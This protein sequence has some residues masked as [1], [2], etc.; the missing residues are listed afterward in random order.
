MSLCGQLTHEPFRAAQRVTWVHLRTTR[1]TSELWSRLPCEIVW[2]ILEISAIL[3]VGSNPA[4]ARVSR[5]LR[6]LFLPFVFA[7]I[8]VHD[9]WGINRLHEHRR[10]IGDTAALVKCI[11]FWVPR[12]RLRRN[13]YRVSEEVIENMGWMF[14][15]ATFHAQ[16]EDRALRSDDLLPLEAVQLS[17][18]TRAPDLRSTC[19]WAELRALRDPRI[20]VARADEDPELSSNLDQWK[21]SWMAFYSSGMLESRSGLRIGRHSKDPFDNFIISKSDPDRLGTSTRGSRQGPSDLLCPYGKV[22]GNARD[23]KWSVFAVACGAVLSS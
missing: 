19:A 23:L 12:P 20:W 22:S 14:P 21:R 16:V 5:E 15:G 10:Y 8:V 1:S 17:L 18:Y 6:R 11:F 3:P 13:G 2:K 7:K 4:I 9:A